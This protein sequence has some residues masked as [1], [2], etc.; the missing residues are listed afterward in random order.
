M[1]FKNWKNPISEEE[2]DAQI[3]RAKVAAQAADDTEPRAAAV[4]FDQPSGLIIIAL[5]NG[6]FF[7]FPPDLV[8]GLESATP[9]ALNDV[10][11]DASG[12]SVHWD[13]LDADF[14]IAGLVAGIFGT[15]SWMSEMGRKGGRVTSQ[16]KAQAA[17]SNGK[18]GGRPKKIL[19][20]VNSN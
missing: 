9:E 11:L 4:S 7:S 15:K 3:V 1:A 20:Q 17:R 18:K 8:Q 19:Q 5:K 2:L 14:E 13:S 12:S 16:I 10:W 6:A